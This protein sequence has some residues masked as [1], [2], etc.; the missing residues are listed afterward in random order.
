MRK[1][2]GVLEREAFARDFTGE[3]VPSR[4]LYDVIFNNERNSVNTIAGA[5]FS[6]MKSREII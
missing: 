3:D 5:V 1:R 2:P 4:H 6:L